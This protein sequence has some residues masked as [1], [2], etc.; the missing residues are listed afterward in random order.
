MADGPDGSS[1]ALFA[2]GFILPFAIP[3]VVAAVVW[4]MVLDPQIG[5][6]DAVIGS[7]IAW[8]ANYPLASII[9]IDAWKTM[10]FV[11]FLLYAG[12]HVDRPAA[13]RSGEARRCEPSG[14]NSGT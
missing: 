4:K 8:F 1:A 14:R 11:M 10:P 12:D 3:G 9:V 13:V 2:G 6:L 5:P 7:P